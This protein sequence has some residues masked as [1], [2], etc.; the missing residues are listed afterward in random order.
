MKADRQTVL[1]R[2]LVDTRVSPF[3]L[4]HYRCGLPPGAL[5]GPYSDQ[6]LSIFF[7]HEVVEC[8]RRWIGAMTG[9]IC[10]LYHQRE[11][12]PHTGN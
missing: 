1:N 7:L 4:I 9:L 3:K 6:I 5:L 8:S 10:V 12:T 11:G 2:C